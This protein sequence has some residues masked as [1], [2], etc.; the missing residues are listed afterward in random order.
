VVD[1]A[2]AAIGPPAVDIGHCRANLLVYAPDLADELIAAW[3]AVT[4]T[5]YDRWADIAA[6][7]GMLDDL[8]D[9]PPPAAGRAALDDAV[10]RAVGDHGNP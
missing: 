2:A 1:W 7:V 8:Q 5:T 4:G 9:H 6:I 3:E 10:A